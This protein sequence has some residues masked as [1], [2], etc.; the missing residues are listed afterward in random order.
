MANGRCRMHGGGS[1]GPRTQ[2]GLARLRKARTRTGLH[3]AEMLRLREF[4]AALRRM[5]AEPGEKI[6]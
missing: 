4:V 3:T 5:E 2:D 6:E 1:T